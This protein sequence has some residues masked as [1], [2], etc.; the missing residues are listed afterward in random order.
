MTYALITHVGASSTDTNT[1]TTGAINT[2]GADF[3]AVVLAYY[4]VNPISGISDSKSNSFSPLTVQSTTASAAGRIFYIHNPAVGSGHTFS[5]GTTADYPSIEAA[6][7]SG[8]LASPFDVEN[9]ANT[10]LATS[11]ATGSI[12]PGSA[13]ELVIAGISFDGNFSGSN[14]TIGGGFTITD[15]T[16]AGSLNAFGGGLAYLIQTTA[17]AANPTWTGA[18]AGGTAAA[19]IASFKAAASSSSVAT[20]AI[21]ISGAFAGAAS[22]PSVETA[23]IQI[24]GA[25]T[26]AA[27]A[28][29]VETSA[30]QIAGAFTG[31]ASTGSAVTAAIQV[32]GAFVGASAAASVETAAIQVGAAF[33]GASAA[34]SVLTDAISITGAFVGAG[35]AP[36]QSVLTAGIQVAAAFTGAQNNAAVLTDS[37]VIDAAWVGQANQTTSAT[38]TMAI[39][40]DA[41]WSSVQPSTGGHFLPLTKKQLQDRDKAARKERK[42]LDTIAQNRRL[43]ADSIA[44]EMREALAPKTASPVI[45]T[46]SNDDEDEDIEWLLLHG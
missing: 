14:P 16:G 46:E 38:A 1:V 13:N 4:T 24:A 7:F 18:G 20:M 10:N 28:A 25:F 36:G 5:A 12:T 17:T 39:G 29:S 33:T 37:I 11:L 2:T 8:S 31:V 30:I 41:A 44:A 27:N 45:L 22:I 15:A 34:A 19:V 43:D 9:G 35:T 3:I 42:R 26:G 40:I 23:A 21:S 32:G 6:A